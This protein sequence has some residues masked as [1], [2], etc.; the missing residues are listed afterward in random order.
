MQPKDPFEAGIYFNMAKIYKAK[1]DS[2]RT[3]EY[4]EKAYAIFSKTL[5]PNHP[6]TKSTKTELDALNE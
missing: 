6:D 3:K 5:G 1:K 2:A 4:L